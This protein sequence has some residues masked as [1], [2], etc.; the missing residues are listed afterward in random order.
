M[1]ITV[2]LTA[3][4]LNFDDDDQ[5]VLETQCVSS[6]VCLFL[7]FISFL[8]YL[9]IFSYIQFHYTYEK[10][11]RRVKT[12]LDDDTGPGWLDKAW[13]VSRHVSNTTRG[14][15]MRTQTRDAL[16]RVSSPRY[17]LF[18]LFFLYFFFL[19]VFSFIGMCSTSPALGSP[20]PP[21]L[22]RESEA[23]V[24]PLLP[25]PQ[26]VS[27]HISNTP[28]PWRGHDKAHDAKGET[29][30]R[31]R[32][33]DATRLEPLVR[34][35]LF[36]FFFTNYYI[37][38][39]YN[40]RQQWNCPP[41]SHYPPHHPHQQHHH[42]HHHQQ[43]QQHQHQHHQ[44]L[45]HDA[46]QARYLFFFLF[47]LFLTTRRVA[48]ASQVCFILILQVVPPQ[49]LETCVSSPFFIFLF[50]YCTTTRRVSS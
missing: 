11:S 40:R 4:N 20:H 5:R 50:W 47:F 44:G 1:L 27:I 38:L 22:Q 41:S 12:R 26:D 36:P 21:S 9:L 39:D 3:T 15:G 2:L 28:G 25:C 34:F 23:E 42:H 32:G 30:M 24:F 31:K 35:S 10:G 7:L 48:D 37:Y 43:Q 16:R 6:L 13:D 8:Y 29:G 14:D 33:R 19:C 46:S 18:F 17:V 45:R 49:G